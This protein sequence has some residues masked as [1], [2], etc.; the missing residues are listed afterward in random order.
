[1]SLS[2]KSTDVKDLADG[3]ER[4]Q[5]RHGLFVA[6]LDFSSVCVLI[7]QVQLA[8]RHPCKR[9]ESA[10][11]ARGIIEAMIGK[12]A[13]TEPRVAELLRMGFDPQHDVTRPI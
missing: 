4:L 9:G 1:M 2:N 7:A 13:D 10:V 11:Q 3:L 6:D 12:L 5:R 8:L